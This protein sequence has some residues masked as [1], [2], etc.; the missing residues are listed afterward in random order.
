ME[1]LHRHFG[2]STLNIGVQCGENRAVIKR[3]SE[4]ASHNFAVT[5]D[6]PPM[7][8]QDMD[9][10]ELPDVLGVKP[11]RVGRERVGICPFP[12]DCHPNPS[13]SRC[14]ELLH[15]LGCSNDGDV[16]KF[17]QERESR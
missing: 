9:V 12:G 15:H 17:L 8:T 6:P 16:Q 13:I 4:G 10:V 7:E 11:M 14:K 1:G 3:H 5:H 2:D